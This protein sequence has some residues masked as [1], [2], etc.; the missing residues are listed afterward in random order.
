[1]NPSPSPRRP[2]RR[3]AH[4]SRPHHRPA[5]QPPAPAPFPTTPPRPQEHYRDGDY[6]CRQGGTWDAFH[7]VAKVGRRGGRRPAPRWGPS[8]ERLGAAPPEAC[9]FAPSARTRPFGPRPHPQA[10]SQRVAAPPRAAPSAPPG[11]GRGHHDAEDGRPPLGGARGAV[12]GAGAVLWGEAPP[13]RVGPAGEHAPGAWRARGRARGR[14]HC[15]RASSTWPALC[16]AHCR[17]LR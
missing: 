10:S 14:G 3:A 12:H 2:P 15:P 9:V 4:P 13:G 16:P 17:V 7:I 5:A 8:L 6:I 11:H 1:M